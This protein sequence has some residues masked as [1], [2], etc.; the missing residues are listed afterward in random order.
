M[1]QVV[2]GG[3]IK[4]ASF[5]LEDKKDAGPTLQNRHRFY[6]ISPPTL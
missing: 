3:K 4:T 6:S 2:R 1:A 5:I